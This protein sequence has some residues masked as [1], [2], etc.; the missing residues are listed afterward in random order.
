VSFKKKNGLYSE[1]L[2]MEILKWRNPHVYV[3]YT[4]SSGIRAHEYYQIYVWNFDNT[5]NDQL[6]F[7]QDSMIK[8]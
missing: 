4:K 1:G 5:V 8:F 7:C 6:K 3:N 2:F